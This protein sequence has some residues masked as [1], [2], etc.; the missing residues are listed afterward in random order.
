MNEDWKAGEGGGADREQLVKKSGEERGHGDKF[1][2][3]VG[4]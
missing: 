2:R 3:P 4:S 1:N